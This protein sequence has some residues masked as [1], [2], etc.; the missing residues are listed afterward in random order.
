MKD[1]DLDRILDRWADEETATAPEMRPAPEMYDRV[2]AL[3]RRRRPVLRLTRRS[4]WAAV[5]AAVVVLV[6]AYTILAHPARP[7]VP[8]G[9]Q[10]V[11]MLQQRDAS[12]AD[13]KGR[14]EEVPSRGKGPPSGLTAFRQL[15]LQ[16]KGPRLTTVQSVDLL[17]PRPPSI[18]LTSEDSYRLLLEPAVEGHVYVFQRL[19]S[20]G[21]AQLFPAEVRSVI[22][23]PLQAA[24]KVYLP[25][26]PRGFYVEGEQ[27]QGVL[28]IVFADAPLADLE[29][30]SERASR[31]SLLGRRKAQ[32]DLGAL[33]EAL[34][35]ARGEEVQAWA[36]PLVHR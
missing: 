14:P 15:L 12:F 24:R 5:L 31:G 22:Q 36:I 18:V 33:L 13:E 20:G 29:T 2:A 16:V 30:L 27:G 4:L 35:T 25:A 21:L 7:L 19:P 3:E 8:G 34:T 23:N 9:G 10:Q 28:Y 6:L 1:Q 26:P 17:A 11:A 32:V